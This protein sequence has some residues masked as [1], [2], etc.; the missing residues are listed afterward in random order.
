M[1]IIKK[2]FVSFNLSLS[3]EH[4]LYI[5][6]LWN[7]SNTVYLSLFFWEIVNLLSNVFLYFLSFPTVGTALLCNCVVL[8]LYLFSHLTWNSIYCDLHSDYIFSHNISLTQSSRIF[9]LLVDK[10]SI[11]AADAMFILSKKK[12]L[13]RRTCSLK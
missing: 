6:D 7:P 12:K 8:E 10:F 4:I 2:V 5:Y 11:L 3:K 13:D 9:R 1:Q